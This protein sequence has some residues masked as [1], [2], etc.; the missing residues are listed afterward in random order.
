M[1][2]DSESKRTDTDSHAILHFGTGHRAITYTA[3]ARTRKGR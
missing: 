2:A 1:F 3:P